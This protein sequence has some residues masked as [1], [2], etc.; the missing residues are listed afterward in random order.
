MDKNV[1]CAN[2]AFEEENIKKNIKESGLRLSEILS[3][4]WKN[5]ANKTGL[6]DF[7]DIYIMIKS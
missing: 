4:Y 3:G 7:Q 1:E 5:E 6:S 2:I